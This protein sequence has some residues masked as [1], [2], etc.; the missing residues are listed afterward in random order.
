M[1][2]EEQ[3]RRLSRNFTR[4]D[5]NA[6]TFEACEN[7]V[8]NLKGHSKNTLPQQNELDA[9]RTESQKIRDRQ[10]EADNIVNCNASKRAV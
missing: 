7:V 4:M 2:P 1:P 5:D 6:H 9:N 8:Q 10:V 3:C